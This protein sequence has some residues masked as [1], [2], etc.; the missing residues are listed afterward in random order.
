MPT[1]LIPLDEGP[2]C[3]PK[4]DKAAYL[5]A[6]GHN[7]AEAARQAGYLVPDAER[8]GRIFKGKGLRARTEWYRAK[9]RGEL[10][11]TKK[12]VI[13]GM[14]DAVRASATATELV[15]AWREIGRLIGAYEEVKEVVHKHEVTLRRIEEMSTEELARMSGF[16]VIEGEYETVEEDDVD[17]GLLEVRGGE[18]REAVLREEQLHGLPDLQDGGEQGEA[19]ERSVSEVCGPLQAASA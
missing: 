17:E 15:A 14:Q 12:D 19:E 2:R 8:A 7:M 4:Q 3:T 11:L 10:E 5:H 13:Q 18:A 6:S 1:E 16:E 9:L